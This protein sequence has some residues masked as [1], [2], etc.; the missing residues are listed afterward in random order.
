MLLCLL[1]IVVHRGVV[2]LQALNCLQHT[3]LFVPATS[4]GGGALRFACVFMFMLR[5]CLQW[6]RFWN[7]A[8]NTTR[9]ASLFHA[10]CLLVCLYHV[11][12]VPVQTLPDSLLRISVGLEDFEDLRDDLSQ[13]FAAV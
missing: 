10:C 2:S 13:A 12:C 9:C 5:L 1:F 7:G 11:C 3:Q 4:L 8:I 6:S